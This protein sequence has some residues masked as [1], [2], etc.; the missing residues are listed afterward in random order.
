MNDLII[1][2]ILSRTKPGSALGKRIYRDEYLKSDHWRK[3]RASAYNHY[4]GRCDVCGGHVFQHEAN[5]HHVRYTKPGPRGE[6]VLFRETFDD[7][8]LVHAGNCHTKADRKRH[9]KTH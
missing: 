9:A 5:I 1:K 3:F 6:S 7:V 8:R 2:A 4:N